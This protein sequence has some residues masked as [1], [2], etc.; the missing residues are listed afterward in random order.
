MDG[1][2][3]PHQP[4]TARTQ[5][6]ELADLDHLRPPGHDEQHAGPTRPNRP[7]QRANP[8]GSAR[9]G[10]TMTR[11]PHPGHRFELTGDAATVLG[12]DPAC[13]IVLAHV[14]VSRRHAE[15]L[16]THPGFEL[17]DLGS[18]NGTYVN[19]HATDTTPLSDG[20]EIQLGIFRLTLH[21]TE[22]NNG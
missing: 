22:Q 4:A 8:T 1:D 18:L 7:E 11:G 2:R 21:I 9:A 12:R 5:R 13:D 6:I 15:I 3:V 14:T 20:D 17:T 19:H 10:L 16:P